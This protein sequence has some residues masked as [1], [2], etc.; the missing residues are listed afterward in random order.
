MWRLGLRKSRRHE[1]PLHPAT[2]ADRVDYGARL[3]I[4]TRSL[5]LLRQ[6]RLPFSPAGLCASRRIRTFNQADFKSA[7]S[8]NCASDALLVGCLGIEP[9]RPKYLLYRQTRVHSGLTPRI[10]R[11][12]NNLSVGVAIV[13]SG[14]LRTTP[15]VVRHDSLY[16][17]PTQRFAVEVRRKLS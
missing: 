8:A 13:W 9:N 14:W 10:S 6:A 15:H 11:S 3:R 1:S 7:A 17:R 2:D 12:V 16:E 4:R 5:L